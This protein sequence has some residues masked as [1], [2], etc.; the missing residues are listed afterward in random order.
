M[1]TEILE[2]YEKKATSYIANKNVYQA[3]YF[4]PQLIWSNLILMIRIT[5]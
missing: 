3:F 1:Q 4:F 2:T 5:K